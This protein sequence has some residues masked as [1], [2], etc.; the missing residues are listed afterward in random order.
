[1]SS[2]RKSGDNKCF[3]EQAQ[4]H[5]SKNNF[6]ALRDGMDRLSRNVGKEL[7]PYAA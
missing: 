6:L 5:L 1:M 2:R 7:P 3:K 4:R